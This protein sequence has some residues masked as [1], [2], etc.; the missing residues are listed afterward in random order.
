MVQVI[1][2]LN[3]TISV[4]PVKCWTPL[5]SNFLYL[6]AVFGKTWS[7]NRL[8][9]PPFGRRPSLGFA[10]PMGNP[11]SAAELNDTTYLKSGLS[12]GLP[13]FMLPYLE[14]YRMTMKMN[15]MFWVPMYNQDQVRVI[16]NIHGLN[17]ALAWQEIEQLSL[18]GFVFTN[19]CILH[20]P[21]ASL[22]HEST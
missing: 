19:V 14:K 5:R 4:K 8:A 21:F 17:S 2:Q 12:L 7:N 22:P 6:H 10:H 15:Q 11:R 1:Y 13:S 16:H 20:G 3:G 9:S 18:R